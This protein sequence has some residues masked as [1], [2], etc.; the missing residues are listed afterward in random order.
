MVDGLIVVA[1]VALLLYVVVGL[2]NN[3]ASLDKVDLLQQFALPVWLTLGVLPYIYVV[4]LFAA[5]E[6]AF[7]RINWKSEVGWWA[8]TRAKLVL[9]TSFHA[10]ARD[11]GAFSGPWQFKLA[12][13]TSFRDGRRVVD[14]FRNAQHGEARAVEEEH[15]RLVRFAGID[16]VGEDG[17]RLDRRE[18]DETMSALRWIGTCQMGWYNNNQTQRYRTDLLDFILKGSAGDRLPNPSGVHMRVSDDGQKW[19]AWRRTVS[20]WVFA[21]GAAG[22]PPDQWEY[23]GPDPPGGFPGEDPAWGVMSFSQEANVNW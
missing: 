16:G 15:S 23:D 17:R 10:K 18:F 1:S 4:G 19:F 14:A 2:V 7:I 22:P 9:L 11:V 20:G 5:Y 21:I 8:R 6:L 12:S 3:W 13:A